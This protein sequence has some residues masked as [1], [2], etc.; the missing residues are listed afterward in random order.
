M[1]ESPLDV[2]TISETARLLRC[3]VSR[4]RKGFG[5]ESMPAYRPQRMFLR[6]D[7]NAF[8]ENQSQCG[9]RESSSAKAPTTGGSVSPG[10]GS[11][12]RKAREREIAAR[13]AASLRADA[14][15]SVA[16]NRTG[17]DSDG[18]CA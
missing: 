14:T 4:I 3:S 9:P 6:R 7:V 10:E 15:K 13:L 5:P 12:T 16:A 2:L 11:H 1:S 17:D 8:L 18:D